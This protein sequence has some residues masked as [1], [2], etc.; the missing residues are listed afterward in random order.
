MNVRKWLTI[1]ALLVLWV[2]FV[3]IYNKQLGGGGGS[4]GAPQMDR[5]AFPRKMATGWALKDSSD[6]LFD[7]ST[8]KGKLVLVNVWATWCP[9][10]RAELPSL[11]NL[12]KNAE[13]QD[14]L[15]VICASTDDSPPTLASYQKKNNLEF[16]A[17]YALEL[18]GDFVTQA[19]PATFL[20]HD[21][22][23]LV[24]FDVG[25]ASWD[26]PD[27]IPRLKRLHA[28]KYAAK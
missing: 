20:M 18:P 8:T 3:R 5:V 12:A 22:G 1:A 2:A 16:P 6:K 15:V 19:I 21:D 26:H 11:A 24:A 23:T 14:K 13:L 28:E 17:Y 27:F 9:P 4:L 7:W 25:S 10:C